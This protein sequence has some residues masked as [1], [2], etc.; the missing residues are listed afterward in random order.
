VVAWE[1]ASDLDNTETADIGHT[2]FN[3][4]KTTKST[5]ICHLLLD[6]FFAVICHSSITFVVDPYSTTRHP[7]FL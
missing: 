2:F 5:Y 7:E 6:L 3:T 4:A 1:G